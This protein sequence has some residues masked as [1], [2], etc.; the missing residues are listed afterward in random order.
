MSDYR[1]NLLFGSFITPINQPPQQA[2]TLARLSERLGLDI[3]TFQ[4]HPYQPEY[5]D[6]WTL[7]SYVAASTTSISIA[8]NVANLPLRLPSVLARSVASLDLL[9]GGRVELGLGAGGFWDAIAAFGGQRLTPRESVSALREAIEIIRGIWDVDAEH[10]LKVEGERYRVI[11]A[12]RGPAPSHDIGIWL[13]AYK[14][15]MLALT[16]AVADGWLPSLG[17]IEKM[18]LAEANSRIDEAAHLAGRNPGDIRRLLNV[19]GEFSPRS[20]GMLQGPSTQWIEQLADLVLNDGI[21]AFILG[22]DDPGT[23]ERFAEEVAP[24]L[25]ELVA[26]ERSQPRRSGAHGTSIVKPVGE[27]DVVSNGPDDAK[28][29]RDASQIVADTTTVSNNARTQYERL[30]VFPTVDDGVRFSDTRVWDESTRPTRTESPADVTYTRVGRAIG[31]HLI[32]VHDHLRGELEQI[33]S[34]VASVEAG[35]VSPREAIV[36]LDE[37]TIRQNNWTIGAYCAAYYRMVAL[38]HGLE[39]SDIFPHLRSCE[40]QL[41]P[42]IDRLSDEHNVIHDVLEGLDRALVELVANPDDFTDLRRATDIL[43]DAL[44]S[45]LSY[46]EQE[47]VEP[48]AR[49]GFY[50]GQVR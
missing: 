46:E 30:G 25:R 5:L 18:D 31:S 10:A 14:P 47:L 36:S 8:P 28:A 17:Y 42:V 2:V 4:D 6:T 38:H 34:L 37:F 20:S 11:G 27:R 12:K 29:D 3:V 19:F 43:T 24:A 1:H 23:L 7:L 40:E 49:Y 26:A 15:A 48:L 39:D 9:S 22:G 33:R 32:A 35:A 16:G 13:G 50:S 44:L 41:E 21:S 45:H